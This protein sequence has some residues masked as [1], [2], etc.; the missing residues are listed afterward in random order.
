MSSTTVP[1]P[2]NGSFPS[3]SSR[4]NAGWIRG[5]VKERD[6]PP[7]LIG[8]ESHSNKPYSSLIEK[9]SPGQFSKKKNRMIME[10]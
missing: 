5:E 3:Q 2:A 4:L 7:L 10:I 9:I 6:V 8:S 1:N